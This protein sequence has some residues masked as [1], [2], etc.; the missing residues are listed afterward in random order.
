MRGCGINREC[1][2]GKIRDDAVA[3]SMPR[4]G[5]ARVGEFVPSPL[6]AAPAFNIENEPMRDRLS[7][8]DPLEPLRLANLKPRPKFVSPVPALPFYDRHPEWRPRKQTRRTLRR[9]L[10]REG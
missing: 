3:A 9:R 6:A 5:G 8:Q 7:E 4:A 1:R 10:I 2:N